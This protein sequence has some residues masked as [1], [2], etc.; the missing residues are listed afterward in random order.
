MASDRPPV[1]L[2]AGPTASGKS[3]LAVALAQKLKADGRDA[4]IINADASQVYRD[5]AI[6][7]ARPDAEEM[8]GIDHRL[9][10]YRDGAEPFSAADW[11][12]DARAEIMAAHKRNATPILVGGTGMYLR[13]LLDGI[14]PVPDIAPDIRQQVRDLT[15]E[16]AWAAL[17]KEDS[18]AASE[19]HPNDTSRI[20]R[21]LEVIRQTGRSITQWRQQKSGGIGDE[22]TLAP[23]ILLPPRDWLY[24]RCDQRFIDMLD[25]GA[26]SEVEALLARNLP[27]TL[28]VMRAIGVPQITVWLAGEID[29]DTMIANVQMETRRY[30]KRQYTWF[31]NQSDSDWPRHE[32]IINIENRDNLVIKLYNNL[33]T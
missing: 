29:R 9:F 8:A 20:Q 7:S 4:V 5:L 1:A 18:V 33:L 21:A 32:D 2:I 25:Q 24:A 31:G 28:P 6:L 17:Q 12:D 19:L 30:A 23:L 3:G 16:D 27:D 15:T 11:A 10:G 26:I 14:A 22:I 13:T